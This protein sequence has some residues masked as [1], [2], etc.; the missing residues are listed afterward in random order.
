MDANEL[1]ALIRDVLGDGGDEGAS[2][3]GLQ[4]GGRPP[5]VGGRPRAD[6]GVCFRASTRYAEPVPATGRTNL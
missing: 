5:S 3:P 6:E 2:L 4:L 1:E